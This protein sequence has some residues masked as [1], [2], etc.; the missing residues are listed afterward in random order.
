MVKSNLS[1]RS[2]LQMELFVIWLVINQEKQLSSIVILEAVINIESYIIKVI[3]NKKNKFEACEEN[4]NEIIASFE[5]TSS[6]IYE[7]IVQTRVLC[8]HPDFR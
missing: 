8:S 7:I 3:N 1:L 5:E 6:C 4:S 2:N